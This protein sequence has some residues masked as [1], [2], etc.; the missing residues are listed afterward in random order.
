M[1]GALLLDLLFI[2]LLS[3]H[4][5][6]ANVAAGGPLACM[7]LE[8]KARGNRDP[9]AGQAAD[10]LARWSLLA[11]LGGAI[12]GLLLGA[13]LWTADYRQLWLERLAHKA[14][15]AV[16]EYAV[17][18]GVIAGYWAWRWARP[19]AG[20]ATAAI[21]MFLLALAA[22]NL[23]YHFPPL[24]VVASRLSDAGEAT[25]P[26]MTPALFRQEMAR[27][28]VVSLAAHFTLASLA[29]AG[30]MLLG[31]ALRAKR[32]GA[33]D[34]VYGRLA[35]WGGWVALLP[36]LLQLPVGVWVLSTIS[37]TMQSRLMGGHLLASGCFLVA[38]LGALWLMRELAAIALGER[39][40]S[41]LIRT[42]A[43]MV[44]VVVLMTAG[45]QLARVR[46]PPAESPSAAHVRLNST[47][48]A[49]TLN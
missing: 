10:Y 18:L 20:T 13:I 39:E 37:T 47:G 32:R 25:G 5:M 12:L 28:E 9:L 21:R 14:S 15:W 43:L 6:L 36:T 49:A 27:G 26:A 7:W 45:Q 16:G 40:R 17:S 41:Q 1:G 4:L 46:R 23:L 42:M 22:T 44:A 8:W 3:A 2:L 29:M 24:F 31:L 11:L 19:T 48:A 35:R 30:I 34:E 38:V 33:S